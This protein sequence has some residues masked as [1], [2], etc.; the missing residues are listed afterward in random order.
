MK[1]FHGHWGGYWQFLSYPQVYSIT[2]DN[3]M[4]FA[5]VDFRLV[6][7]GGEAF[8]KNEEGVWTLMSS[9]LTWIE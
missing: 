6:Y 7:Q 4:K 3:D 8:L 1:I 2:F 5:R 9:K